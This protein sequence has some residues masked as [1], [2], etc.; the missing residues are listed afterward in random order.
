METVC[1]TVTIDIS[2]ACVSCV[3]VLV[4]L[5]TVVDIVLVGGIDG[6][7]VLRAGLGVLDRV[8]GSIVFVTL[9]IMVV[10]NV[11]GLLVNA[12]S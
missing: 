7:G 4:S 3:N 8:D 11:A 6:V 9:G 1:V 10:V 2:S 12:A 5:V